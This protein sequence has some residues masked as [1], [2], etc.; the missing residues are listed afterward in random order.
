MTSDLTK[1]IPSLS[2]LGIREQSVELEDL[3][4]ALLT[5]SDGAENE[6]SAIEEKVSK[7]APPVASRVKSA[8]CLV[9]GSLFIFTWA[10][11]NFWW[12]GIARVVTYHNH[13]T[14]HEGIEKAQMQKLAEGLEIVVEG[15]QLGQIAEVD[16]PGRVIGSFTQGELTANILKQKGEGADLESASR[17]AKKVV[18]IK[19]KIRLL[20]NESSFSLDVA[21]VREKIA[22]VMNMPLYRD[23]ER[24][25]DCYAV[26]FLQILAVKLIAT[27]GT[28][29]LRAY[30][31]ECLNKAD[32]QPNS[33]VNP[34]ELADLLSGY[35]KKPSFNVDRFGPLKEGRFLWWAAHPFKGI[36]ALFSNTH[37]LDYNGS[38][39]N[40]HF[41]AHSF[42]MEDGR[43]IDF[44]YG[45]GPTGDPLFEH[46]LLPAYEKFGTFELRFNH[47]NTHDSKDHQRILRTRKMESAEHLHAVISFDKPW[48]QRLCWEY[49]SVED[50]F[51]KLK[52][53]A[54]EG[55][56]DIDDDPKTDNG[57][58]IPEDL[59][60]DEEVALALEKAEEFCHKLSESNSH[61]RDNMH[62][63]KGRERMGRMMI[64]I[65]D[66]FL[67][68]GMLY[69]S[70]DRITPQMIEN[71]MND[72]LDQ[73]L[74]AIRNSGACK[75]GVDRAVVENIS[76]RLFFRWAADA[77][78][79]SH[80]EV[81]EIA[82][83]VF[84]RARIVDDRNI[85]WR[86]YEILDDLLRFVGG[87][88]DGGGVFA[89]HGVL[90]GY[91]E[92]LA[93]QDSEPVQETPPA[94]PVP[95]TW[96]SYFKRKIA[97]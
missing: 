55:L 34:T 90:K 14:L 96:Y 66:T 86:R 16:M 11:L 42:E 60:S 46:G 74:F 81:C 19:E 15:K 3:G 39:E 93:S 57:L 78:P 7:A 53:Y 29:T 58:Y 73:D 20:K 83:S 85:Q 48:A 64:L 4:G 79:L 2:D 35:L 12:A 28:E 33:G 88:P 70:L 31:K 8:V 84:G 43:K 61:W 9:F 63:P 10:A 47:Q 40:P 94:P 92:A 56:R 82:G 71:Q 45:A 87:V 91:R 30:G 50:F 25:S 49:Y 72:R 6:S 17:M 54:S 38:K 65:A 13:K 89:A 18:E 41:S 52:T 1:P 62:D 76:L 95:A 32:L 27:D 77:T 5:D 23:L 44:Y 68:L 67:T 24:N 26:N 59:F 69:G 80:D 97:G 22:E 37:P 21:S 36:H 51:A 75:Q